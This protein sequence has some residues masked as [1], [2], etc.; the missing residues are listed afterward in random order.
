MPHNRFIRAS[1]SAT[2]VFGGGVMGLA[3]AAAF[4]AVVWLRHVDGAAR[5][6]ATMPALAVGLFLAAGV[7]CLAGWH[8]AG[9][10]A[11]AL[12]GAALILRGAGAAPLTLL[13]GRPLSGTTVGYQAEVAM[14]I[15][16]AVVAVVVTAALA[17][18]PVE[19]PVHPVRVIAVGMA[20]VLAGAGA[21]AVAGRLSA[22]LF[23]ATPTSLMVLDLAVS[24]LWAA[25][26]L[27]AWTRRRRHRWALRIAPL[28][29]G[30]A[31][32]G[33]L[34][35]TAVRA[36]GSML[37]ANLVVV[38]VA[39]AAVGLTLRHVIEAVAT[40]HVQ[41]ETAVEALTR[42]EAVVAERDDWREELGHDAVNSVAGLRAAVTT[43]A[44]YDGR[45]D[46]ATV[47]R[48]QRAV[49][50]ELSHLEHLVRRADD[51]RCRP[52]EVMGVVETVAATRQAAGLRVE[53]LGAGGDAEGRPGDLSTVLHNLLVNAERHAP[54]APVEVRVERVED[55]VE[56]SV[57]DAGPGIPPY[58]AE[59]VF[60]RGVRGPGSAGSGLGLHVARQ[61]MRAQSGEL[62]LRG[63]GSGCTVVAILPAADRA[64]G[65]GGS[66]AI[67]RPRR[68]AEAI[69]EAEPVSSR[70]AVR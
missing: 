61:L 13:D 25:V 32:A 44:R 23:V 60:E 16:V 66:G 33:A 46:G 36:D 49:L 35:A 21:I 42:A 55:R 26:A 48:L 63:G 15:V 54:G 37:P 29:L 24:A 7:L 1:G 2:H 67:P 19:D 34:R 40:E 6:G 27:L 57:S 9:G 43:L 30:M 18:D 12:L 39:V 4:A 53:L 31:S 69:A 14:A 58:L 50:S 64:A 52:F 20:V 51:E 62:E 68:S 41:L 22:H 45:L 59:A 47:G 56:I 70:G 5:M 65:T 8:I 10:A 3:L 38:V 28:F 17:S 11:S